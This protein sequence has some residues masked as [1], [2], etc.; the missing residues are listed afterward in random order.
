MSDMHGEWVDTDNHEGF[1]IATITCVVI[2]ATAT[3]I[4]YLVSF[5]I[6]VML[7]VALTPVV[8]FALLD[9]IHAVRPRS[10]AE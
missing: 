3:S 2:V 8:I 4:A 6:G 9:Y 7:T 5:F 10:D 1:L